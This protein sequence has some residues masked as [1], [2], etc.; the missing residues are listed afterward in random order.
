MTAQP[1]LP[2]PAPAAT[3]PDHIWGGTYRQLGKVGID[4][5]GRIRPPLKCQPGPDLLQ[6]VADLLE[7]NRIAG[8]AA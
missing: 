5:A 6:V 7:A 1:V 3:W 2:P 4:G 8:E